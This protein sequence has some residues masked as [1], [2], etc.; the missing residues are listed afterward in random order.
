[1]FSPGIYNQQRSSYVG[2]SLGEFMQMLPQAQQRYDQSREMFDATDAILDSVNI[3]PNEY[4]RQEAI[5]AT[6][7]YREAIEKARQS[8]DYRQLYGDAGRLSK[9]VISDKRLETLQK[10]YN[11]MV[12]QKEMESKLGSQALVF[13][14]P[15]K[16]RSVTYDDDG[17]PIYNVYVP[18]VEEKMNWDK[19]KVDIMGILRADGYSLTPKESAEIDGYLETG[20]FKGITSTKVKNYIKD[21]YDRYLQTQEGSQEIKKLKFDGFTDEQV[22]DTISRELLSVGTGMVYS[23]TSKGYM[24][25]P[26][27]QAAKSA[28][29]GIFSGHGAL[30]EGTQGPTT[31]QLMG[32][33]SF[34]EVMKS[35]GEDPRSWK[36]IVTGKMAERDPNKLSTKI[37]TELGI[38]PILDIISSSA[39]WVNNIISGKKELTPEAEA[40]MDMVRERMSV[41]SGI[42]KEQITDQML[43]ENVKTNYEIGQVNPS[44]PI[45]FLQP[46]DRKNTKAAFDDQVTYDKESG[47]ILNPGAYS[48]MK[49]YHNGKFK[50]YA[51]MFGKNGVI[52]EIK[53]ISIS[54]TFTP[55]NTYNMPGGGIMVTVTDKDGNVFDVPTM[56]SLRGQDDIVNV[57]TNKLSEAKTNTIDGTTFHPIDIPGGP[58]KIGVVTDGSGNIVKV[59]TY[60]LYSGAKPTDVDVRSEEFKKALAKAALDPRMQNMQNE[61]SIIALALTYM[62]E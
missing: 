52:P 22:A 29:D 38:L 59:K 4:E 17:N 61:E 15:S 10:S 55:L 5:I 58:V 14:D 9:Q 54:G 2:S 46:E 34:D 11:A 19:P 24:A 32:G 25:N 1:M 28:F 23:E 43:I 51:E 45:T 44:T 40:S 53:G 26:R 47:K 30:Q 56:A 3:I 41:Q 27:I 49:Y 62:F 13:S 36:E 18:D 50:S 6:Q 33:M 31:K 39:T 60:P 12:A 7:P 20:N 57:L 21:A 35:I 8:G 16:H 42:P 37:G 48:N